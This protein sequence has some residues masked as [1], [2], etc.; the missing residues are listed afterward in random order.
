MEKRYNLVSKNLCNEHLFLSEIYNR[1]FYIKNSHIELVSSEASE[2][3][4]I[5]DS[6]ITFNKSK[7]FIP[8]DRNYTNP[9]LEIHASNKRKIKRAIRLLEEITQEN[10][11]EAIK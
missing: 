1:G 6:T 10:L 11:E 9:F 7:N 8:L 5:L 2:I 3:Y 4:H